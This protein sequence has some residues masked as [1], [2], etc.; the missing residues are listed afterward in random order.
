MTEPS[1]PR[2]ASL[3]CHDLRT[4][5]ATVNG[6]AKTL[7]ASGDL[8]ERDARFLGMIDEA[9]GQMAALLDQLGLA[10]RI[11]AGR[12]EPAI[13]EADP[14]ELASSGDPRLS[15]AGEGEPFPTDGAVVRM[16]LAALANAAARYGPVAGVTWTVAG[17]ELVLSPVTEEAAPVLSGESPRDL[18]AL[19]ARIAIEALGGSI[20][21]DGAALRVLL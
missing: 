13:A 8:G 6:F 4:P 20:A 1:F 11:A 19:V 16:S 18:G 5:L 3:A 7:L 10:A 15:V 9:A 21:V 2:L 17:R 14:V 12:Y